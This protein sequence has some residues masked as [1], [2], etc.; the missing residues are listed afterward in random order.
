MRV[1]TSRR[2][3]R[4]RRVA[5]G[6]WPE[7]SPW[8][9]KRVSAVVACWLVGVGSD[10]SN[11]KEWSR[12]GAWVSG[13]A[14]RASSGE[15]PEG[16]GGMSDRVRV[17]ESA[18]SRADQVGRAGRVHCPVFAEDAASR[19]QS[20][21]RG[22]SAPDRARASVRARAA[23]RE[24][25]P[26]RFC[27]AERSRSR[28]ADGGEA[29]ET[30]GVER[31]G[32][33]ERDEAAAPRVVKRSVG[34]VGSEPAGEAE[35]VPRPA[36]AARS[37]DPARSR[38]DHVGCVARVHCPVLA[39]DSASRSQSADG[40]A[41]A[42]DRARETGRPCLRER[43]RGADRSRSGAA[44]REEVG[45]AE[46]AEEDDRVRPSAV[47]R[48]VG[49]TGEGEA[50]RVVRPGSA[51]RG[52]AADVRFAERVDGVEAPEEVKELSAPARSREDRVAWDERVPRPVLAEDSAA[53]DL[54]ASRAPGSPD[55]TREV[56][57][58]RG[59]DRSRTGAAERDEDD[60]DDDEDG[61]GSAERDEEVARVRE[62]A[63]VSETRADWTA[64]RRAGAAAV[65]VRRAAAE[66][67]DGAVSV[68]RVGGTRRSESGVTCSVDRSREGRS[69]GPSAR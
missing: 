29:G 16:T 17:G 49:D 14:A 28:G 26:D 6:E 67:A 2:R 31:V 58:V 50:D 4:R 33:A 34:T 9:S 66:R 36:E 21:G 43:V 59:A 53:R 7:R 11:V 19:S 57:R 3:R 8:W 24:R 12:P 51:E 52:R 47:E 1:L 62:P 25:V 68:D 30:D 22:S 37:G 45:S 39:E 42:S 65:S 44:E 60:E 23:G 38:A 55:R 15:A 46:R 40:E 13:S 48:G 20:A 10:A 32:S 69:G 56:A 41:D 35:D 63:G 5:D 18:L 61:D 54:P 27:E 64:R